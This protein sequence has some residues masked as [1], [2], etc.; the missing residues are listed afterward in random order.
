M[1]LVMLPAVLLTFTWN[2]SPEFAAVVA[3]VV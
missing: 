1:L 2:C 3:G